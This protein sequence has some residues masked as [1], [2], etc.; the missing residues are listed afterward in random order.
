MAKWM[1]ASSRPGMG[2]SRGGGGAAG[3][4][5]GVE[6]PPQVGHG[7]ARPDVGAGHEADALGLHLGE[8]P[9]E[10][11][12]LHLEL[13][14]AVAQEPADPV[15]AL[16]HRDGVAGPGE[17]LGARRARPGPSRRRP[18]PCRCGAAG[19]AGAIQP[20]AKARSTMASSIGLMVTGSSLIPSTHEPS[21]GAGHSVPVNSGKLLVACR[22]SMASR[23]SPR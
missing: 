16:E 2:R 18:P 11:A 4:E 17:L 8:P 22:R 6:V 7:H 9:V 10:D 5:Q 21:H 20:S 19:G 14:D 1:P 3:Q 13:G 12:L 23:Q 15:G